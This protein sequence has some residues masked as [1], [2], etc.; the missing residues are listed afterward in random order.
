MKNQ[1]DQYDKLSESLNTSFE[2]HLPIKASSETPIISS[3]EDKVDKDYVTVRKNLYEL[4]EKGK[5]AVDGILQVADAGDA[6]RAYEVVSQLL[7]TVSDMNKD[8]LHVHKEMK[9]IKEDNLNLTQKNTTNN[10]IYVGSTS[11]LQDLINPE[12]S[13][14]KNIKKV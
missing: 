7:K 13:T 11:E 14:S 5:S 8:V 9:S 4:I 12:R 3:G 1:N 2:A 10:T 6:P